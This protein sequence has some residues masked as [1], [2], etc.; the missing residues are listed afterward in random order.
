[1]KHSTQA[2]VV[3]A[4]AILFG[5]CSLFADLPPDVAAQKAYDGAKTACAVYDLLP[6]EKHTPKGDA[7]CRN[8][9]LMCD[10]SAAGAAGE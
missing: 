10:E 4:C 2:L 3:F 6:A 9:R 1:M 5:A 7:A 8:V